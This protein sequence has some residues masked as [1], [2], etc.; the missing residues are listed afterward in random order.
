M[1]I[2]GVIVLA[3]ALLIAGVAQVANCE[4]EGRHLTLQNGQQAPMK[5]YWTAQAELATGGSL[6]VLGVLLAFSRR[7][8]S[9]RDL[10][11]VG[12]TLGAFAMLLPTTLIGV[13]STMSAPCNLVMRPAM[14]F[15]GA[16]VIAASLAAFVVA[17]R[18]SDLE[19]AT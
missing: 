4:R 9:R 13:C 11:I 16:V 2:L 8:E 3:S 12:V 17:G 1:R 10:G 14:L 19:P 5:C 6:A 15:L 7:R 18:T